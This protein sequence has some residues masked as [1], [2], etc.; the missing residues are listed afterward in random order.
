MCRECGEFRKSN[1]SWPDGGHLTK[2]H[3]LSAT[4]YFR[5][6]PGAPLCPRKIIIPYVTLEQLEE[7][8][9]DPAWE[10]RQGKGI[11]D[12]LVC[13]ECGAL[14]KITVRTHLR[15]RHGL[16]RKD[17]L[18]KWPSARLYTF[19]QVVKV[20]AARSSRVKQKRDAAE[21]MRDMASSYVTHSELI[22]CRRDCAWEIRHQVATF[23]VCRKCGF[24]SRCPLT[25][26]LKMH[27]YQ[28]SDEYRLDYPGASTAAP[29]DSANR[30]AQEKAYERTKEKLD[31]GR[32]LSAL[33]DKSELHQALGPRLLM[34]PTLSNDDLLNLIKP[35]RSNGD[36]S[37][38]ERIRAKEQASTEEQASKEPSTET[39]RRIRKFCGV[40]GSSGRPRKD[41]VNTQ[42]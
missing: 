21:L 42:P 35:K 19:D 23:V 6:W 29:R 18:K 31:K 30:S 12:R 20:N 34:N 40:R 25:E 39:L 16:E 24:K 26:H 38:K 14:C 33:A 41:P 13:R 36:L 1:L 32:I 28:G 10:A 11:A 2:M 27:G 37:K 7:C 5:E 4:E 17:Y 8:R 9:L 15:S 22:E 3:G